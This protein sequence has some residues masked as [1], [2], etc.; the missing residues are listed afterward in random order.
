MTAKSH[1]HGVP[2][3][4]NPDTDCWEYTD[5]VKAVEEARPCKRCGRKPVLVKVNVASDLSGTGKKK[6]REYMIDACIAPIVKA[7]Q[8]AGID[9]R[10]SCC[11][12]GLRPEGEIYLQDGRALVILDKKGAKEHLEKDRRK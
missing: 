8:D 7:L 1:N 12:H 4:Y 3:E 11:G 2:I 9:M 5:G 6:Y 10:G